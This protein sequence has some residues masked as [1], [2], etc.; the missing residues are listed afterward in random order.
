MLR[1]ASTPSQAIAWC[2]DTTGAPRVERGIRDPHHLAG[3]RDVAL[4]QLRECDRAAV[5]TGGEVR[6]LDRDL[7]QGRQ[8]EAFP[9]DRRL[10]RDLEAGVGARGGDAVEVRGGHGLGFGA[11]A[12]DIGRRTGS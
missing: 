10:Q 5:A 11:S 9:G 4:D 12:G 7:G 3:E 1:I 6:R 8:F 2:S